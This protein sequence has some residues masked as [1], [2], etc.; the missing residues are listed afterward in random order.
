MKLANLGPFSARDGGLNGL[1]NTPATRKQ[2]GAAF[3]GATRQFKRIGTT[4]VYIN[5]PKSTTTLIIYL[6]CSSICLLR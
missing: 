5:G 2:G 6:L 1:S 3:E 4:F